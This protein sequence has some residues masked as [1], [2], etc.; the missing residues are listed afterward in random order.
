MH[1]LNLWTGGF[2][3]KSFPW[4]I[5]EQARYRRKVTERMKGCANSANYWVLPWKLHRGS[6][7]TLG[8]ET[9]KHSHGIVKA[10][11]MLFELPIFFFGLSQPFVLSSSLIR[12]KLV[13]EESEHNVETYGWNT[14]VYRCSEQCLIWFCTCLNWSKPNKERSK[15]STE[16]IPSKFGGTLSIHCVCQGSSI[17]WPKW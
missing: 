11:S 7:P 4:E 6:Y 9:V 1:W 15:L 8:V 14:K 10:V 3:T 17:L 5:L 16:S 2:L 13:T 12:V